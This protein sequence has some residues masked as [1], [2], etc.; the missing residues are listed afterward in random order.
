MKKKIVFIVEKTG[1]GFS[2]YAEDDSI[3]ASTSADNMTELRINNV[4]AYNSVAEI[5]G[6]P[7]LTVDDISIQLD[8]CA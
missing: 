3:P 5:K 8:V 7:E 2:T 1:T 6:L 4:D